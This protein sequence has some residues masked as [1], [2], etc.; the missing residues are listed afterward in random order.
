[1]ANE[2]VWSELRL[3]DM[4]QAM[5]SKDSRKIASHP[6]WW[7]QQTFSERT[8]RLRRWAVI[9][10]R[11]SAGPVGGFITNVVVT[12]ALGLL[13]WTAWP[14][15]VEEPIVLTV[16][17]GA[18]M[19]RLAPEE[20]SMLTIWHPQPNSNWWLVYM[21]FAFSPTVQTGWWNRNKT[22]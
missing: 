15:F 2:S 19:D 21:L 12:G 4:G 7:L 3:I 13:W 17:V 1:M 14:L 5:W 9:L 18:I 20:F 16:T 11:L 22:C 8:K 10:V 6:W